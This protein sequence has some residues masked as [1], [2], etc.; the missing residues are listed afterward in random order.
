MYAKSLLECCIKIKVLY[1]DVVKVSAIY[2]LLG[3]HLYVNGKKQAISNLLT[4]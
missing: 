3:S 4:R 2:S 1:I